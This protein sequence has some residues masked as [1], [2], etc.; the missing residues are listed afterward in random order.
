MLIGK[1][2]LTAILAIVIMPMLYRLT[3]PLQS[4]GDT[5]V[6]Q[7]P[8][9]FISYLI[10]IGWGAAAFGEELFFRGFVLNQIAQAWGSSKTGWGAALLLQAVIFGIC[11]YSQGLA[12]ITLTGLIGLSLGVFYVLAGRNLWCL[13]LAHGAID[14]ISLTQTYFGGH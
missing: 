2:F 13:I 7:S 6:Y 1:V 3:G 5:S 9:S 10:L 11:H 8:L 14:T 4:S 12:G